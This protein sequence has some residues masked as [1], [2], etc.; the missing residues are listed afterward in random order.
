MSDTPV[1]FPE[2]A[3][4]LLISAVAGFTGCIAEA[5]DDICSVGWTIGETYVPFDPDEDDEC[6][7]E[8]EILCSQAWVR[9]TGINL[10]D[11]PE[12]FEGTTCAAVFQIG[13]EVGVLRCIEIA[14]KAEAP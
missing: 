4:E 10:K 6:G 5:L 7:E 9:I 1:E 11:M 2:T 8:E 13:L 3:D 12:S 14:E